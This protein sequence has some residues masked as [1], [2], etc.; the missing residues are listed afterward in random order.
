MQANI[1]SLNA[2][3]NWMTNGANNIANLNSK[4]YKATDTTLKDN[5]QNNISASSSKSDFG[6]NLSK[7]LTD[8]IQITSGFNA[9]VQA[10]KTQEKTVGSIL[11]ILV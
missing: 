7:E 3:N 5:G 2:H 10:I 9:N 11:N 6:T 1:S 4:N 8:Q